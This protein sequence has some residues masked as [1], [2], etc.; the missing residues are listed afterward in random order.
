MYGTD[1]IQVQRFRLAAPFQVSTRQ[2]K[3]EQG[4][5]GGVGNDRGTKIGEKDLMN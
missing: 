4:A 5:R 2:N 1:S 3:A